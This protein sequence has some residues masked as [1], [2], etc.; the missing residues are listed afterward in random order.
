[1]RTLALELAPEVRVNAVAPGTVLPPEDMTPA[2]HAKIKGRIPLGRLG[3]PEDIAEA[4][5]YLAGAP[6]VTGQEIIVD[7]GRTVAAFERFG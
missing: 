2:E 6:F 5:V 7:G 1:M 4:V 3:T